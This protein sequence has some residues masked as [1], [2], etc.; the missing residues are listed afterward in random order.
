MEEITR[1]VR[2]SQHTCLH[3]FP[4]PLSNSD[5]K[6]SLRGELHWLTTSTQNN[7]FRLHVNLLEWRFVYH[8][9]ANIVAW[10]LWHLTIYEKHL[11]WML[12]NS[13]NWTV[14]ESG[15][16]AVDLWPLTIW[17]WREVDK[18]N[19]MFIYLVIHNFSYLC[20]LLELLV[21]AKHYLTVPDPV[22]L[23]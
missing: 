13:L 10:S 2:S 8:T 16:D 18:K 12:F 21:Y 6:L 5:V 3:Y 4:V 9:P 7:K 14:W 20:R 19:G 22:S 17:K 15:E 1:S 11:G 23:F